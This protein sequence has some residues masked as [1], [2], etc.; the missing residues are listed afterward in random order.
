MVLCVCT[1]FIHVLFGYFDWSGL[2]LFCLLD[3]LRNHTLHDVP[4]QIFGVKKVR[5]TAGITNS[6]LTGLLM[7]VSQNLKELRV[8]ESLRGQCKCIRA[9]KL[10]LNGICQFFV[11]LVATHR[12]YF[13]FLEPDFE[14]LHELFRLLV[15]LH[16]G[17]CFLDMLQQESVVRVLKRIKDVLR[18]VM[19]AIPSL[20]QS[21]Y[22]LRDVIATEVALDHRLRHNDPIIDTTH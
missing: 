1:Y 14:D 11:A 6:G 22:Q 5:S 9:V 7:T 12:V 15:H 2:G 10:E 20:N 3:W 16:G 4:D 17:I 18:K 8:E 19:Q 21:R 13:L